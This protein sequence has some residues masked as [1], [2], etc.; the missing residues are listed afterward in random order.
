[1]EAMSL[2][3]HLPEELAERL[4]AEATRRG[5]SVDDLSAELLAAGLDAHR[6]GDALE[7]FIGSGHSGLGDL[8]RR[9]RQILAEALADKAARE[10]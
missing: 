10:L 3:V 5:M 7:A 9:H 6:Q 1:M 4:A 2:S 8:A